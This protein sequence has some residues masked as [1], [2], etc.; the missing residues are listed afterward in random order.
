MYNSWWENDFLNLYNIN[1][2]DFKSELCI[3]KYYS[4]YIKKNIKFFF[5]ETNH[6][7]DFIKIYLKEK[8]KIL[9]SENYYENQ[10]SKKLNY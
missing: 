6:L 1:I 4:Y 3:D 8:Y 9:I 5:Y 10:T 7:Q 2:D